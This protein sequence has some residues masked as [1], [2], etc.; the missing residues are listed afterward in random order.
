MAT[1][2]RLTARIARCPCAVVHRRRT[3]RV[4]VDVVSVVIVCRARR[5]LAVGGVDLY[6][7][8]HGSIFNID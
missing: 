8:A 1:A 4:V 3:T 2:P 5:R 7:S 6:A